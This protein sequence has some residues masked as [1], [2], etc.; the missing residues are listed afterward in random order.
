[1]TTAQRQLTTYALLIA[2]AAAVTTLSWLAYRSDAAE[3]THA[4]AQAHEA[5]QLAEHIAALRG[6]PSPI[7]SQTIDS[8][9]LA[10]QIT[11]AAA[12][13]G[14][15]ANRVDR[16][17]PDPP[18]RV[19]GTVYK[20][21]PIHVMLNR[22]TLPQIE[23]LIFNLENNTPALHADQLRMVTPRDEQNI[24]EWK[25]ELTLSYLIYSPTQQPT[26]KPQP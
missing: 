17:E 13:A 6:K 20:R 10:R 12:K 18:Q 16:I 26:G 19:S 24:N 8:P 9:D 21:I 11:E 5:T 2:I 1:M 23:T 22:T 25:V 15:P 14:I 3:A 7:M 4:A